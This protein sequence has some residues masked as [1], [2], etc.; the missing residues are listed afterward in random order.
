MHV[1][2]HGQSVFPITNRVAGL[3][4]TV[5]NAAILQGLSA[6]SI[7]KWTVLCKLAKPNY[8]LVQALARGHFTTVVFH[9]LRSFGNEN[10]QVKIITLSSTLIISMW[11]DCSWRLI[12]FDNGPLCRG[13]MY[14]Y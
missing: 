4:M 3:L 14:I 6:R 7:P 1:F 11:T 2:R 5:M 12:D 10:L 8:R 13:S 9:L